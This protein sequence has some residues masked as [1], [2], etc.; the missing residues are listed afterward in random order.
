MGCGIGVKRHRDDD[1]FDR[2]FHID[3]SHEYCS[4]S[5]SAV[6]Y[7]I[8]SAKDD[9]FRVLRQ[10]AFETLRQSHSGKTAAHDHNPFGKVW[11]DSFGLFHD[12]IAV[13]SPARQ[14]LWEVQL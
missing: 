5:L 8:A 3:L 2:S 11:R 7:S 6:S 1:V 14:T 4:C 9:N 12:Q 13:A 10:Q